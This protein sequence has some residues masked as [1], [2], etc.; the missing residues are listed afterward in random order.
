[1]DIISKADNYNRS[2][3]IYSITIL[4]ARIERRRGFNWQGAMTLLIHVSNIATYA[5]YSGKGVIR[6]AHNLETRGHHI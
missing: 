6:Y 5:I 4:T 3:I 2:D 1:M